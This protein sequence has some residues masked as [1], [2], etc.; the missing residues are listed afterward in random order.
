[1]SSTSGNLG[2]RCLH[3]RPQRFFQVLS[4]MREQDDNS[5]ATPMNLHEDMKF[6]Q[7]SLKQSFD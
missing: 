7:V 5:E 4:S 1:M 3:R 6:N 2:V